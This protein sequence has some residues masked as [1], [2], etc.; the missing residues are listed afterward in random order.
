LDF[1]LTVTGEDVKKLGIKPGPEMG[2]KIQELE[3]QNF[4]NSLKN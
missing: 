4:M 3:F 1:K 2:I